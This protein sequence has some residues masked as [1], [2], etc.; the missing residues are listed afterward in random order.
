MDMFCTA[1]EARWTC[2]V[3]LAHILT[4]V[5]M[6]LWTRENCGPNVLAATSTNGW[7]VGREVFE[8]EISLCGF[9]SFTL[10]KAKPTRRTR[11]PDK[12]TSSITPKAKAQS[13]TH[14][15]SA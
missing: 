15:H 11:S 9:C 5:V 13:D 8:R 6:G 4:A 1:A 12:Y 3:P 10:E 7:Y 14:D 2:G